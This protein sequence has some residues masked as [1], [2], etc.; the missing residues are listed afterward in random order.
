MSAQLDLISGND[1]SA[2][3]S[4][5][6]EDLMQAINKVAPLSNIGLIVASAT[7]PDITNNPR[8]IRYGWLDISTPSTPVLKAYTADRTVLVDL[9]ASWTTVSGALSSILTSMFAVRSATGGVTIDLIKTN[10]GYTN[11]GNGYYLLRVAG[12]G[13]DVEAVSLDSALSGGGGVPLARLSQVGL[14]AGKFIGN[15]GGSAGYVSIIPNTDLVGSARIDIP[16]NV[17]PGTARYVA[18]TNAA[19][20]APEWVTPNDAF[21]DNELTIARIAAGAGTAYQTLRRNSANTGNEWAQTVK[22]FTSANT[23]L[24]AS[25]KIL[26]TAHSLGGLPDS[27]N[28]YL[29]CITND[30]DYT[31]GIDFIDIN[32]CFDTSAEL[33]PAFQVNFTTSLVQVIQ[34]N[35]NIQIKKRTTAVVGEE[36]TITLARWQLIIKA[37]RFNV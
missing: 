9:D 18:R 37:C 31:A 22:T 28:A 4:V 34:T 21:A 33:A 5:T 17:L 27:W 15:S 6:Q 2:L 1:L 20:T 24:T 32:S 12:N 19:G 23:A 10:A 13:K 3:S 36:F 16:T 8:F 7:R 11:A 30:G 35:T 25:T 26:D 29:A 14:V